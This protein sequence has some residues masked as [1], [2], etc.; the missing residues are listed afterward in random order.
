M[1]LNIALTSR[2]AVYL[3]A[4][5]RLTV[6]KR[7]QDNLHVQ[8]LISVCKFDWVGLISYSGRASTPA[9]LD[10][11]G[12]LADQVRPEQMDESIDDVVGRLRQADKWLASCISDRELSIVIVGFRG[13]KPFFRLLSNFLDPNERRFAKRPG[14]LQLFESPARNPHLRVFGAGHVSKADRWRL[15]DLLSRNTHKELPTAIAELNAKASGPNSTVSRE[16]VVGYL[17][18]SGDGQILPFVEGKVEEYFPDFVIRLLRAHGVVGYEPKTDE[19]GKPLA[20]GFVGMTLRLEK[21]GSRNAF[22]AQMM[23]FR[24]VAQLIRD[25]ATM[26]TEQKSNIVFTKIVSGDEPEKAELISTHADGTT[27]SVRIRFPRWL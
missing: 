19:H 21:S 26:S 10:V 6:G 2:H 15:C 9:G 13:R 24:N 12:W 1:T 14:Q 8:K 3:S 20:A 27:H 18:P 4:D 17:L 5:F 11:G 16:C 23:A 7:W 22:L 25:T